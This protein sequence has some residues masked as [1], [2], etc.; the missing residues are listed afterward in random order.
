MLEGELEHARVV[1]GNHQ[2][3]AESSYREVSSAKLKLSQQI[4]DQ[5]KKLQEQRKAKNIVG[6]R[7]E[8]LEDSN[9]ALELQV[10]MLRETGA[11][12]DEGA[13]NLHEDLRNQIRTVTME[14]EKTTTHFQNR[15]KTL[16]QV[17]THESSMRDAEKKEHKR[18]SDQ[19]DEDHQH[20]IKRLISKYTAEIDH[21]KTQLSAEKDALAKTKAA[22][23]ETERQLMEQ[24][25]KN[26]EAREE[27]KRKAMEEQR[28]LEALKL[29]EYQQRLEALE[30]QRDQ[31]QEKA[32]QQSKDH[33][34]LLDNRRKHIL[35][36]KQ[37]VDKLEDE[38]KT[39]LASLRD[40]DEQLRLTNQTL[41][42]FKDSADRA[43]VAL[44]DWEAKLS[45][46][47]ADHL[48]ERNALMHRHQ[49]QMNTHEQRLRAV[50]GEIVRITARNKAFRQQRADLSALSLGILS[51]LGFSSDRNER[52]GEKLQGSARDRAKHKAY[53]MFARLDANA[54]G[55]LSLDEIVRSLRLD[56]TVQEKLD[57][58]GDD[59]QGDIQQIK[60]WFGMADA[61][62]DERIS[63]LELI[64]VLT[65]MYTS[66][67]RKQ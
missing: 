39:R 20:H 35:V 52:T 8:Q 34:R 49:N 26:E 18:A 50:E 41:R 47:S 3:E 14:L 9:P 11:E 58:S 22:F 6:K 45:N 27:A 24:R 36:Y 28:R 43:R 55:G 65:K 17:V 51:T 48:S 2:R 59:E 37:K 64:D 21:N 25:V 57:L 23:Q 54:D 29:G 4:L 61:N 38:H 67:D 66:A 62:S 5:S 33:D 32:L 15:C 53:E 40:Y 12:R 1:T 30:K 63:Q 42:D 7:I 56:P 19:A 10:K 16:K 46:K 44:E 60:L 13:Q 31:I